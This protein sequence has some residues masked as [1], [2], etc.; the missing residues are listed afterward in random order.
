MNKKNG[1]YSLA[2]LII[3]VAIMSVLAGL[4]VAGIGSI[5]GMKATSCGKK[6][7]GYMNEVKTD[8][9]SFDEMQLVLG[10]N[11]STGYTATLNQLVYEFSDASTQVGAATTSTGSTSTSVIGDKNLEV[12]VKIGSNTYSLKTHTVCL[13][14][15]SGTGGFKPAVVKQGA[16]SVYTAADKKY[17]DSIV[18]KQNSHTVTIK[19]EKLTGKFYIE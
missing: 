7:I 8:N 2:E 16:T 11:S 5:M 9:S 1:G 18:I 12:S 17:V 3:I 13:E 10:Y 15:N 19:C 14:F 6:L 4:A